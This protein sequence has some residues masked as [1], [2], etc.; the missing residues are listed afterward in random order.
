MMNLII[1]AQPTYIDPAIRK[2]RL[3]FSIVLVKYKYYVLRDML[4]R[5]SLAK[6]R[7]LISELVRI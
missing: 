2:A 6:N 4:L 5:S 3:V 7:T 1:L